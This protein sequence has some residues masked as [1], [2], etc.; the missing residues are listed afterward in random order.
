[1][2]EGHLRITFH[3]IKYKSQKARIAEGIAISK[4]M[5]LKR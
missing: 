3:K 5:A 1:M 4:E 2:L